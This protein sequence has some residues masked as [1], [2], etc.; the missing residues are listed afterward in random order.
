MKKEN[1]NTK[2]MENNALK[3][4]FLKGRRKEGKIINCGAKCLLR[5]IQ[6]LIKINKPH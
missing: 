3:R 1:E 6:N 2:A 4:Q 5:V